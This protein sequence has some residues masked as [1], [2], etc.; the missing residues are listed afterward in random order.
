MNEPVSGTT[1]PAALSRS[2][3]KLLV[4]ISIAFF[5]IFIAYLA[6]FFLPEW[7]PDSTT[8]QGQLI[9]PPLAAGQI[10]TELDVDDRWLLILPVTNDCD[11]SCEELLY[12]SRQITTGLGKES[13]RVARALLVQ[14]VS[15]ALRTLLHE[16]H[17]DV[18]V[19]G[20]SDA[21]LREVW[22][23]PA[24]FLMD[25]NGNIMMYFTPD[26]AGKP[27]LRDLKHLLRVSNIG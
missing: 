10:S 19:V 20:G 1:D 17:R 4:I 11:Q 26:K 24:L 9:M 22:Q 5:P 2:R 16:E 12:L 27:M 18:R 23:G 7:A 21:A 6:Y 25:P 13:S 3:M 8:N 14:E 15:P